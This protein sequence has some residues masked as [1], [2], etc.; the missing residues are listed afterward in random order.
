[1]ARPDKI[2]GLAKVKMPRTRERLQR[3]ITATDSADVAANFAIVV[4]GYDG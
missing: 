3:Q 4:Y 2:V 1:M